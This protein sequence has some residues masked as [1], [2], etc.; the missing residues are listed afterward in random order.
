MLAPVQIETAEPCAG[1]IAL[2]TITPTL[3]EQ[4]RWQGE[5]FTDYPI[6]LSVTAG[7][8]YRFAGWEIG[9]GQERE[10]RTETSL[11]LEIPE[12][13][14]FIKAVFEEDGT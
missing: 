10:I 6:T 11:E 9:E 2:N 13:G 12:T 14:L 3:D 7:E 1:R 5:Y 8:G 4:G